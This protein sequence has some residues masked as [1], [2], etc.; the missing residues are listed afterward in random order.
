MSK[1]SGLKITDIRTGAVVIG[2][3]GVVAG[4][5]DRVAGD[6]IE[7]KQSESARLRHHI[8]TSR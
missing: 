6:R 3:D 5:V 7:L 8:G 2:A 4:T 1:Q